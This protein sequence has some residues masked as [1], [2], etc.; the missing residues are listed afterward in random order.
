MG[1]TVKMKKMRGKLK[2]SRRNNEVRF[3]RVKQYIA[4]TTINPAITHRISDYLGSLEV[5]RYAVL[6]IYN[7]AFFGAKP[8][9]VFKGGFISWSIMGDPNAFSP[10]PEPV[11]LQT[12]FKQ[13]KS[14]KASFTFMSKKSIE[15][16]RSV[17]QKLALKKLR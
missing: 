11:L 2:E 8:K 9:M 10:T 15:L 3:L 4:K 16:G 14:K 7:N 5:G 6:V 1:K 17:P 12:M 13:W